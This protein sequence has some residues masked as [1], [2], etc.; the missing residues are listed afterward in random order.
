MVKIALVNSGKKYYPSAQEPLNLGI[1]AGY[2][3]KSGI[4]VRIID[5]IAGHD[6][7]QELKRFNP[8][9]VGITGTTPTI[10]KAYGVADYARSQ[11]F[12]V[13]MGG[14]HVSALPNEALKHCDCVI[15][16]EAEIVFPNIL[17]Q[18]IKQKIVQGTY[19][20]NVK[21]MP[22]LARHLMDM[23]YYLKSSS[24][25][26]RSYLSY[27]NKN[28]KIGSLITSRGCPY[29]CIFCYNSWRQSPVRFYTAEYVVEEI[30][31]LVNNYGV[32][33][34][35]FYD[36]F[37]FS[38]R[39]RLKKI[40]NILIEKGIKI[41]WSCQLRANDLN[42]EAIKLAIKA[43]CKELN[44]GFESGSQRILDILKCNTITV[45]QNKDAVKL[46]NKLGILSFGSFMLGN[47]TETV[48]DIRMTQKFIKE[49]KM[50]GV[51]VLLTTPYPGTRL[52]EMYKHKINLKSINW[53]DF[54]TGHYPIHMC[55]MPREKLMDLFFETTNL[56]Y[57]YNKFP[58]GR[59]LFDAISH[60]IK[61]FQSVVK[62]PSKL[63]ILKNFIR[64]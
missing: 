48:A 59:V 10:N 14:K 8:D 54:T 40:C 3:L 51:G 49:N 33:T 38:H 2:L 7:K 58:A 61:T 26:E 41:N 63:S 52:W 24:I 27:V 31:I 44:F 13:I 35:F 42:E 28:S 4:D 18:G 16:D 43:G 57:K 1:L 50:D 39:K 23:N 34:I 17:K 64:Q 15:L 21:N 19:L 30:E 60:P 46:C 25:N 29:R 5:Q 62:N 11:G 20:T 22:H 32:D 47:P 45:K 37:L 36:D 6:V 55:D 53:D 12:K 9:F 56:S